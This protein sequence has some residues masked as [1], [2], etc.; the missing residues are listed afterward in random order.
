MNSSTPSSPLSVPTHEPSSDS[1][2]ARSL[3]VY[4]GLR[5]STGT[6]PVKHARSASKTK[7]RLFMDA[8]L[9]LLPRRSYKLRQSGR[10]LFDFAHGCPAAECSRVIRVLHDKLL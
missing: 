10:T 7:Y 8:I 2:N 5:E 1:S 4:R 3:S 6:Q 9:G